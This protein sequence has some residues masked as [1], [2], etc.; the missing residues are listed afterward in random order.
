MT[1]MTS[2]ELKQEVLTL[3]CNAAALVHPDSTVYMVEFIGVERLKEE[4]AYVM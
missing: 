4:S 2:N 1:N 3:L